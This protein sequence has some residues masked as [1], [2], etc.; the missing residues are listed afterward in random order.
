MNRL[1]IAWLFT[2]AFAVGCGGNI[3]GGSSGGTGGS[4]GEGGSGGSTSTTSSSS[5]T[6]ETVLPP[7]CVVE[8]QQAAPYAV[9]FQFVVGAGQSAFLRED[10]YTQFT[11][12]S[13]ASAYADDVGLHGDCTG[14]CANSMECIECGACPEAAI[15]I[16]DAAPHSESWD[17]VQ[18]LFSINQAGCACHTA[19]NA[20]AAK[21]R[22]QVPVYPSEQDAINQQN[23][24]MVYQEFDLPA[25]NGIVT[26]PVGPKN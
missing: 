11:V 25:P 13:C 26:I 19:V 15:Q 3:V 14:D 20:P 10:C 2:A 5:S 16:S 17:G 22:V 18:Y 6:T 4:G 1:S 12:T 9:T 8:T 7:Q 21:Y 24:V 23:G